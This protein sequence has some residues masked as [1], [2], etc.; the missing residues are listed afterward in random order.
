[1]NSEHQPLVEELQ[2]LRL[3]VEQLESQRRRRV[4][5]AF[6]FIA[7]AL[8]SVTAWGQLV[9]FAPDAPARADEVNTN[10]TQLRNWLEQKVGPV[11]TSTITLATP[12]AGS[13][14]ADNTVSG[15]K[16]QDNTIAGVDLTDNTVASIDI[17]DGTI[18]NADLDLDLNC[19]TNARQT[20]GQ[21]IFFRPASGSP[22]IYSYRVAAGQ[23]RAERAHLCTIGELSAAHA[24]GFDNCARGWLGDRVNSGTAYNGYPTQV[25]GPGCAEGIN[26][27]TDAVAA[28]W[29]AYCCK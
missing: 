8:V 25:G 27:S 14:V 5:S 7:V 22:Y 28:N 11:G 13:M 6:V 16:V 18:G 20:L 21:C 19:P 1:M 26:L 10:F 2:R 17:T 24:S 4:R 3:R 23:C 9:V 15:T 12:L 29:G